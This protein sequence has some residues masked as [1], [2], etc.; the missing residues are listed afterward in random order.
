MSDR[1]SRQ[2]RFAPIG[3]VGQERLRSA[4]VLVAGCGALG[5]AAAEMLARAGVGRLRLV[6]RDVVEESNLQRQC[7]YAQAD[8]AE[9]APKALA[10]ARRLAAIDPAVSCEAVVGE[11]TPR[12]VAG[13]LDGCD[14]AVDGLDGFPARHLLNEAC[15]VAGIPWVFAA[16]VG[17]YALSAPIVPGDGA[18]LRC[19]QDALP[20]PGESPTC[21]TAG[22][23]A[24]AVQLAAAWQVAEALKILGGD[25]AALRRELW[26][27]DL[28]KGTFQRLDLSGARDPA[29]LACGP[30]ATR[31]ALAAAEEPAVVLCGR[32][33]VQVRLPAAPDLAALAAGLGPVVSIANPVL[34]RWRDAGVTATCFADGRVLVQGVGDGQEARAFVGRWVS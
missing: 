13:L 8:A 7:L 19:L 25:R 24:P 15:C 34:V 9:G 31:P 3:A 17:A 1:H 16:C 30:R 21:D 26:A 5:S 12:T 33:A 22:I 18:C 6:D 32:Q 11:I 28:W 20:A 10:A 14:L 23:I 2:A 4:R 27:C 29:C